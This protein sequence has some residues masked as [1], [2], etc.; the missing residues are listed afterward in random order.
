MF[1]INETRLISTSCIYDI[2]IKTN[3]NS[4]TYT[5]DGI[6]IS[7]GDANGNEILAQLESV[8]KLGSCMEF[9]NTQVLGQ[10][11]EKICKIHITST[12]VVLD[13]WMPEAIIASHSYYPPITFNFNYFIPYG[14]R[15][16][17]DYCHNN[18]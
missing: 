8:G 9:T 6:S 10:C 16:G 2:S 4:P 13:G 3:C 18:V 11:I 7:I 14:Q 15:S 1:Q 5:T 12:S 17:I